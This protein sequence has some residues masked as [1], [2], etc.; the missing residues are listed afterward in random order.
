MAPAELLSVEV[1]FSPAPR[2]IRCLALS[3]PPGAT[4]GDAVAATGWADLPPLAQHVGIWG[5]RAAL[6]TP[7]R[8]QDRVEIYRAIK[9]DPKEARRVR[10]RAHGEKLPKGFKRPQ[11]GVKDMTQAPT[12]RGA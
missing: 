2:Q 11:S 5:R 9:V 10:Y 1:V 3:L 6:D 12:K 4:L 8:D 7:L